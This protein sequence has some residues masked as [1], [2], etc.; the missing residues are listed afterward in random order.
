[1]AQQSI[2]RVKYLK[3][4]A[5]SGMFQST[6]GIGIA[7]VKIMTEGTQ[8]GFNCFTCN[9]VACVFRCKMGFNCAVYYK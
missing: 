8:Y 7:I 2:W 4:L 9:N 5:M 6:E 1:M 3:E